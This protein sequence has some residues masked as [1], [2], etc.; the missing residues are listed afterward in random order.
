MFEGEGEAGILDGT[1]GGGISSESRLA[2]SIE[3]VEGRDGM[4]LVGDVPTAR[5]D[6]YS[7]TGVEDAP[8]GT[9]LV[10]NITERS[11]TSPI[12]S[13]LGCSLENV[14]KPFIPAASLLKADSTKR[15]SLAEDRVLVRFGSGGRLSTATEVSLAIELEKEGSET[16]GSPS[17]SD[18]TGVE[19]P[20]GSPIPKPSRGLAKA[21]PFTGVARSSDEVLSSISL[22]RASILLLTL[23]LVNLGLLP[24]LLLLEIE[25]FAPA[26]EVIDP[27]RPME[28]G[29]PPNSSSLSRSAEEDGLPNSTRLEEGPMDEI[30]NGEKTEEPIPNS[31]KE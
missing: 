21:D 29:A 1:G 2:W 7:S 24:E 17:Y 5:K 26:L 18:R 4:G 15:I 9:I 6:G 11:L 31:G 27:F 20:S 3:L 25:S 16:G 10:S 19:N 30:S 23:S 13:S 28:E 22:F 8:E 12:L 14:N